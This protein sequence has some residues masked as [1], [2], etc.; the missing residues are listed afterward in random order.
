MGGLP[1]MYRLFQGIQNEAC[2]G[3]AAHPPS[4]D[5]ACEGIDHE[6]HIDE[7]GPGRDIGEVRHP[8]TIGLGRLEL[9][10]HLVE[11]ARRSLV[12]DRGLHRLAPDRPG[13]AEITHQPL[14]GAAGHVLAFA[15]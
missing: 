14:D 12:A 10:V 2:M 6:G 7:P 11:R 4:D 13:K 5:P 8:Q 15:P 3:R 1:G 9:P